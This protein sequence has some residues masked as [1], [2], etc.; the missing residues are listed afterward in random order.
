MTERIPMSA[1]ELDARKPHIVN[2]ACAGIHNICSWC[3][4]LPA[5]LQIFEALNV[6]AVSEVVC[7]HWIGAV[8]DTAS[9]RRINVSV[10][11]VVADF[12]YAG[13][14]GWRLH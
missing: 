14:A 6:G 5:P 10:S 3:P 13:W 8:L 4:R 11:C 2:K 1:G 12:L 9:T 7:G